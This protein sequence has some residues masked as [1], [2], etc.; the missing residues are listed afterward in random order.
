MKV[1]TRITWLILTPVTICTL[2]GAVAPACE[3]E[4]LP[5]EHKTMTDPETGAELNFLTTDPASDL[6]LYF[7]ERSWLSDGSLIVFTSSRQKGGTLGY[8]TATGELVRLA[9]PSGSLGGVTAAL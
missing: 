1:A 3:L 6:N 5:P 2:T 7:H 8:V 9:T 4:V